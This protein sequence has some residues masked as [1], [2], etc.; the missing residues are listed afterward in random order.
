MFSSI[1]FSQCADHPTSLSL[2]DH[3][4]QIYTSESDA[5][6]TS[7]A[8]YATP[9]F[10]SD[11]EQPPGHA[12][13]ETIPFKHTKSML[14]AFIKERGL[15]AEDPLKMPCLDVVEVIKTPEQC[16]EITMELLPYKLSNAEKLAM[17]KH[18]ES[19]YGHTICGVLDKGHLIQMYYPEL[20]SYKLKGL[21][22]VLDQYSLTLG[23]LQQ[24][25]D[26]SSP[27]YVDI[28]GLQGFYDIKENCGICIPP[29]FY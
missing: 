28:L 26:T 5:S 2:S 29:K 25:E 12:L 8:D 4:S 21:P 22:S 27:Y 13:A 10:L 14:K 6:S 7:A 11:S 9:A 16:A 15:G 24:S 18:I 23:P 19:N 3:E 1:T 20:H 17:V